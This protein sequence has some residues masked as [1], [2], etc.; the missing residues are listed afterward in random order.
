MQLFECRSTRW[1]A[2]FSTCLLLFSPSSAPRALATAASARAARVGTLRH[3]APSAAS[4]YLQLE[5][6]YRKLAVLNFK[7]RHAVTR[8]RINRYSS[9]DSF[10]FL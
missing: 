9:L 7:L 8:R 1:S 4:S 5:R 2:F 3:S 6:H 10:K